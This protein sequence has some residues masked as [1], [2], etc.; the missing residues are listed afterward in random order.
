M[1]Q[2]Y[3]TVVE[4]RA[5]LKR[6]VDIDLLRCLLSDCGLESGFDKIISA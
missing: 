1:V 3:L 4:L 6:V 5:L 2:I